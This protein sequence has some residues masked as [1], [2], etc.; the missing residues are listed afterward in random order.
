VQRTTSGIRRAETDRDTA[1]CL[2]FLQNG[3]SGT[4][5]QGSNRGGSSGSGSGSGSD[6]GS[7]GACDSIAIAM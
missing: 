6:K 1:A 2:L 5:G 4:G 7:G 3:G